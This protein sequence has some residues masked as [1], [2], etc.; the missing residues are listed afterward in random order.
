MT[1][2]C[3]YSRIAG[4]AP[5]IIAV[6]VNL[7]KLSEVTTVNLLYYLGWYILFLMVE[8]TAALEHN[9]NFKAAF[10]RRVRC[11]NGNAFRLP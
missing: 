2:L 8:H 9:Q 6:R 11:G 5:E 7:S 1:A 3:C 10:Q 4:L